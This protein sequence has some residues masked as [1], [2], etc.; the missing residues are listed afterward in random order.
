M[1]LYLQTSEWLDF[2]TKEYALIDLSPVIFSIS[3][4]MC[5]SMSHLFLFHI[6]LI[7]F[8]LFCCLI[9]IFFFIFFYRF[10]NVF[11]LFL[12]FVLP[13]FWFSKGCKLNISITKNDGFWNWRKK[14]FVRTILKIPS[15][16][17][18]YVN[19]SNSEVAVCVSNGLK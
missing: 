1:S 17:S 7:P 15:N 4:S 10:F 11:I 8:Y 16:I 3:L 19:G 18:T 2:L 5:V 9:F 14:F 12:W 6:Y 13:W